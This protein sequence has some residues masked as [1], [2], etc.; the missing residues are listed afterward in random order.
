[1][2]TF[3]FMIGKT[4]LRSNDS[5]RPRWTHFTLETLEERNSVNIKSTKH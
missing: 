4:H 2:T 5:R 3:C 1:M